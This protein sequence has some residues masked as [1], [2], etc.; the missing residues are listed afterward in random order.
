[1]I[2]VEYQKYWNDLRTQNG[3][4][5]TFYSLKDVE[6]WLFD[7]ASRSRG[8][9]NNLFFPPTVPT[10]WKANP[11]PSRIETHDAEDWDIWIHRIDN[12]NGIIF[13]DGKYTSGMKHWNEE[14]KEWLARCAER[15][16]DKPQFNFV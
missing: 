5:K 8:G 16:A 14:V 3:L 10:N 15:K 6:N 9:Y 1:M 12:E 11:E 2:R 4:V 7:N 13:S